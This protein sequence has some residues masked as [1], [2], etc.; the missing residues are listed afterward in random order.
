MEFI[1]LDDDDA[2]RDETCACSGHDASKPLP[3]NPMDTHK[4]IR[5]PNCYGS[6][7]DDLYAIWRRGQPDIEDFISHHSSRV[8]ETGAAAQPIWLS[9]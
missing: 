6:S 4:Q 8:M 2:P 3:G 5:T 7:I 1:S 9:L